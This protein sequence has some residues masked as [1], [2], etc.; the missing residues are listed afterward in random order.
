MINTFNMLNKDFLKKN[1]ILKRQQQKC[2]SKK[3]DHILKLSVRIFFLTSK[4]NKNKNQIFCSFRYKK[5]LKRKGNL[6]INSSFCCS[7]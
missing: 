1:I 2:I 4:I 3:K 5:N 6:A 7:L